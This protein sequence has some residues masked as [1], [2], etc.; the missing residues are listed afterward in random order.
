MLREGDHVIVEVQG[1]YK[2]H[3]GA[4]V[5]TYEIKKR[6]CK[7]KFLFVCVRR[8]INRI[9]K[10]CE[11]KYFAHPTDTGDVGIY[12][13][14]L[15]EDV[16][17]DKAIARKKTL[18]VDAFEYDPQGPQNIEIWGGFK[19]TPDRCPNPP[20][21]DRIEGPIW[22]PAERELPSPWFNVRVTVRHPELEF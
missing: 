18:G 11:M 16:D 17:G 14:F 1:G 21:E 2:V 19:K 15:R 9:P 22:E 20:S 7:Y 6:E 12:V 3:L 5:E 8:K 4:W 13:K 10:E